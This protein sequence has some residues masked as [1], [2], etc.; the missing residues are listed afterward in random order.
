MIDLSGIKLTDVFTAAL[1]V[2]D[3]TSI[4]ILALALDLIFRFLKAILQR[5]RIKV[6]QS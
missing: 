3:T 4:C 6:G 1:V 2:F 5:G